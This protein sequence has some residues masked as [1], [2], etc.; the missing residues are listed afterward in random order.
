MNLTINLQ[1]TKTNKDTLVMKK[2][3]IGF[4]TLLI[5]CISF[6][7]DFTS[8]SFITPT[9]TGANMTLGFNTSQLD[10]FEGGQIAAFNNEGLCIG[11]EVIQ[12]GFFTMAIWGDDTGTPELDGLVNGEI[13][14]FA[15]LT[16]EGNIVPISSVNNF[17]G[18]VTNALAAS[19]DIT[20]AGCTDDSMIEYHTQGY[21]A[22]ID[23]GSCI[24]PVFNF[25]INPEDFSSDYL[26][27]NNMIIGINTTDV[28]QFV[29]GT[30]G[31]FFDLDQD[32]ILDCIN[33]TPIQGIG[34]GSNGFFTISLWGN[35]ELTSE[36]DGLTN[37]DVPVFAILTNTNYVIAFQSV[38]DFEGYAANAFPSFSEITFDFTVYGCMDNNYCN[39]NPDAEEDDGS[40]EGLPG[41]TDDRYMEYD[42]NADC[43]LE[44]GCIM[45]WQNAYGTLSDE[46]SDLI[47]LNADLNSSILILETD[48]AELQETSAETIANLQTEIETL[49]AS[50][51]SL[52][53]S[54][55]NDI[56]SLEAETQSLTASHA[57]QIDSLESN[58]SS[59]QSENLA[60]IE[61]HA[62]QVTSLQNDIQNLEAEIQNLITTHAAEISSL[63][64]NI[65]NLQYE[66]EVLTDSHTAQVAELENEI[67]TLN[68]SHQTSIDS[69]NNVLL[70]Q[71]EEF[72]T[73]VDA[74]NS[75]ISQLTAP[76]SIDIIS[77]WNLIGYTL[78]IEQ[79]V[80]ATLQDI[81][82]YV[83]IVKN[84]NA[85]VYWPEFGFN[86]IGNFIPGQGY[87][88]KVT[89]DI[90]SYQYPNVEGAR[91]ENNQTVPQ[92]VIEMPTEVHPNDVRSLVKVLNILG[93]DVNPTYAQK[94]TTLIYLYSD[95]TVEKKIK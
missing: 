72:T 8:S 52:V 74:L 31:V 20:I 89:E 57:S 83:L 36:V 48:L 13:P 33:T 61:S 55:E 44:G 9:N 81:V 22:N 23:D 71:N 17:N 32:G 25:N 94:G 42:P 19:N 64:N 1:Q 37:G 70:V 69:L 43:L 5:S 77:G 65:A 62:T 40:C 82:D 95:G 21:I 68:I 63:E 4:A 60:L 41:C 93:Q 16:S 49:N 15:V 84:N 34:N 53:A 10:S 18:Y 30:M 80:T 88:I 6:A 85:D 54:L 27:D 35:D 45:T 3:L 12:Y 28:N 91:I 7:Q 92:W 56:A 75:Q 58:I 51:A 14:S 29:G 47:S 11:L 24:N 26:T 2:N 76:I 59:L 73:M 78:D 38:P 79:D 87:Q 67:E 46:N 39:Y 86:G 66:T 90:P 50:N